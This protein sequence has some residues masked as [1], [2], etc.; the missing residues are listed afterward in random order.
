MTQLKVIY[1][2]INFIFAFTMATAALRLRAL[3]L[4]QPQIITQ[5]HVA[6]VNQT[7]AAHKRLS[8]PIAIH[9]HCFSSKVLT[10]IICI[11]IMTQ[12]IFMASDLCI[13]RKYKAIRRTYNEAVRSRPVQYQKYHINP[14]MCMLWWDM[15]VVSRNARKVVNAVRHS[16]NIQDAHFPQLNFL[17][18]M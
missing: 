8:S 1:H 3:R 4:P 5:S 11:C 6:A 18:I 15:D 9:L 12:S 13:C 7:A 14:M 16:G 17:Q 2:S 10:W